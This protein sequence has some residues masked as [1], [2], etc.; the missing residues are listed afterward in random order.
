MNS[1]LAPSAFEFHPRHQTIP[2][3]STKPGALAFRV[4]VSVEGK[5]EAGLVRAE[6]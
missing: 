1:A 2:A 6:G 3:Q 4:R 5:R